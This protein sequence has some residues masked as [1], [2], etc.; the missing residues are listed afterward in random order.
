MP[1]SLAG[2]HPIR[3]RRFARYLYKT[4]TCVPTIQASIQV[5]NNRKGDDHMRYALE[6]TN[7][8]EEGVPRRWTFAP[9]LAV[10]GATEVA[11]FFGLVTRLSWQACSLIV[12]VA[13]A[14]AAGAVFTIVEMQRLGKA[15]R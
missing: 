3:R 10:V 8:R 14:L 5:S 12:L 4:F 15:G 9:F 1:L 2:I 7:Q 11:F 13:A 6:I